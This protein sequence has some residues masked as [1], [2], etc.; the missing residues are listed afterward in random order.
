MLLD[1]FCKLAC[2]AKHFGYRFDRTK[3]VNTVSPVGNDCFQKA[4]LD[5]QKTWLDIRLHKMVNINCYAF[6]TTVN[7]YMHFFNG[8]TCGMVQLAME[9]QWK[10]GL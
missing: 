9:S 3:S 1:Y 2:E 7:F 5:T 8:K 6:R 10:N 4:P